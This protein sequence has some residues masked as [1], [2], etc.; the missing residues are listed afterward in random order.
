MVIAVSLFLEFI[1]KLPCQMLKLGWQDCLK[2]VFVT[3]HR[4]PQET[5]RVKMRIWRSLQ[6][7]V[8]ARRWPG[9][10]AAALGLWL[11]PLCLPLCCPFRTLAFF[12][13]L[14]IVD[15]DSYDPFPKFTCLL[16]MC[17]RGWWV[18]P[19]VKSQFAGRSIW[20]AQFGQMSTL[21]TDWLVRY[22]ICV[23]SVWGFLTS[24]RRG[25]MG[26][27]DTAECLLHRPVC[28]LQEDILTFSPW[29]VCWLTS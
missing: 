5:V 6:S 7:E 4:S 18:S 27:A 2:L 14:C 17:H 1:E 3:G 16:L 9:A 15:D 23:P 20:G 28:W 22:G 12:G 24:S 8:A 11:L 13:S 29:R 21:E 10:E 19:T 26:R 25:S